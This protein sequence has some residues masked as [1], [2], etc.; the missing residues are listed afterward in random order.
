MNETPFPAFR[1]DK[2][3]V[4]TVVGPPTVTTVLNRK[5]RRTAA[6]LFRQDR[7]LTLMTLKWHAKVIHAAFSQWF[8]ANKPVQVAA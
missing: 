1:R 2:K 5:T 8:A 3:I 4:R 7:P 6:K